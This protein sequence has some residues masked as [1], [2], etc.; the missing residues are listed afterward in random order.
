MSI[1]QKDHLVRAASDCGYTNLSEYVRAVLL[2][3]HVVVVQ[4][5]GVVVVAADT[6]DQNEKD[7]IYQL[8][9][10]LLV[11][12]ADEESSQTADPGK[13][14]LPG[15]PDVPSDPAPD[16]YGAGG[17]PV[18]DGKSVETGTAMPAAGA[19]TGA[20]PSPKTSPGEGDGSVG[21][22]ASR[23]PPAESHDV[24]AAGSIPGPEEMTAERAAEELAAEVHPDELSQGAGALGPTMQ[25]GET[26]KDFM[27]RRTEELRASGRP[28]L[29]AR[30]EAEAEWR[31]L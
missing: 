4:G 31:F 11:Y 7:E 9:T 8:F 16:A 22:D 14:V 21:T 25:S 20:L 27:E 24:K 13:Q 12:F 23:V 10:R 28:M 19:D 2:C 15:L 26:A 30:R 6:A 3:E 29:I 17:A 5:R 18:G 1:A